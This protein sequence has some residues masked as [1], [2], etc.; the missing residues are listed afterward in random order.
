MPQSANW[1][2][3]AAPRLVHLGACG[4]TQPQVPAN[5]WE[6]LQTLSIWM[7]VRTPPRCNKNLPVA[8]SRGSRLLY[9]ALSAKGFFFTASILDNPQQHSAKA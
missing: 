9:T 1:P 2:S 7:A 4:P 6:H 3:S 5:D 8:L